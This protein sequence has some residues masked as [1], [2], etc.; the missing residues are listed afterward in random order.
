MLSGTAAPQESSEGDFDS[1]EISELIRGA[2]IHVD[3]VPVLPDE[4]ID[5]VGRSAPNDGHQLPGVTR[6]V[7]HV[8][9]IYRDVCNPCRQRSI[10]LVV[11]LLAQPVN[12]LIEFSG[13]CRTRDR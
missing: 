12:Q 4:D 10:V 3:H 9:V 2:A 7:R 11:A 1:R 5:G 6:T 8:V 13:V